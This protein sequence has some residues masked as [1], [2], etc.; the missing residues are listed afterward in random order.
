MKNDAFL[1]GGK[2]VCQA[3]PAG[4]VEMADEVYRGKQFAH[5]AINGPH[6]PWVRF[7]RCIAEHDRGGALLKIPVRQFDQFLDGHVAG[8]RAAKRGPDAAD[9]V[10]PVFSCPLHDV[11]QS[12]HHFRKCHLEIGK[13]MILAG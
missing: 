7:P 1:Q 5:A 13:E 12:R 6:L 2:G 3:H 8:Q 10:K 9:Y 4:V 11:G